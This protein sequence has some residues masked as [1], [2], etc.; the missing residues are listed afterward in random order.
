[1]YVHFLHHIVD[2][3]YVLVELVQPDPGFGQVGLVI[4]VGFA[5][6]AVE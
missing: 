6:V 5:V 2:E 4:L 3:S 1:M